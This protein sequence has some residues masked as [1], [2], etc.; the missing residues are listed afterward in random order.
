MAPPD[1]YDLSTRKSIV[2]TFVVPD[3]DN[4][5]DLR[6]ND[7][8][9]V[10]MLMKAVVNQYVLEEE[11]QE[12][13]ETNEDVVLQKMIQTPP[14]APEIVTAS[15]GLDRATHSGGSGG[16][17]PVPPPPGLARG[18]PR[19]RCAFRR[20]QASRIPIQE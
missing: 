1:E 9:D 4:E 7:D 15:T 2:N 5:E 12:E 13:T 6:K 16:G 8:E 14:E 11:D 10:D 18:Q 19:R 17:I 20:R 3:E